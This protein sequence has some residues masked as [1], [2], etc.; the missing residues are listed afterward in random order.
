MTNKNLIVVALFTIGIL[1]SGCK[2][3]PIEPDNL[4]ARG[5]TSIVSAPESQNLN[6]CQP[7]CEHSVV[8]KAGQH[9]SVGTLHYKNNSSGTVDFTYSVNAPWKIIS[10]SLYIGG[11]SQIPTNPSGNTIPGQYPYKK[12]LPDG[13]AVSAFIQVPRQSVPT[14]GCIAAHAVVYNSITGATE[15]AW[16]NGT[17]FTYTNWAM[18]F[19]YC[20]TNCPPQSE[21]CSYP[22]PYWYL[23][24]NASK[25]PASV[26][27]GN[28]VYT[29]GEL[30]AI[31]HY[32]DTQNTTDSKNCLI[33]VATV[34]LSASHVP[35]NSDVW[36]DVSICLSYLNSLNQKLSPTYLPTG[37]T[38]ARLAADRIANWV[39][40]NNCD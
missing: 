28:H 3:E 14:C 31:M 29:P 10:V 15:T 22:F 35:L 5:N 20:L 8:L 39:R 33:Q 19:S 12:T 30:F 11:C 9:I 38:Q 32:A 21:G 18:Y 36:D 16:A 27:V 40:A 7:Q 17:R 25:L 37:N 1:L 6:N 13:G 24:A 23:E 26:T 4:I 2:K 34:N